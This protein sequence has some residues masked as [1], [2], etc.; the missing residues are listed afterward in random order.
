[1]RGQEEIPEFMMK[2]I[3]LVIVLVFV[4]GGFF[5]L[6][7]FKATIEEESG[8]RIMTD[9]AQNVLASGCSAVPGH[10]GLLDED[11]IILQSG[12]SGSCNEW[13]VTE[14]ANAGYNDIYND[15]LK[16]CYAGGYAAE[17]IYKL[18]GLTSDGLP[19]LEDFI[20]EGLGENFEIVDIEKRIKEIETN[21]EICIELGLEDE[22]CI[23]L[24][25]YSKDFVFEIQD[26]NNCKD[27]CLNEYDGFYCLS[28]GRPV[29]VKITAENSESEKIEHETGPLEMSVHTGSIVFPAS[30][31]LSD[32]KVVPARMLILYPYEEKCSDMHCGSYCVFCREKEECENAGCLWGEGCKRR[33]PA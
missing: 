30:L 21:D 9:F 18:S 23:A 11:M 27:L 3:A 24:K 13:L 4:V 28:F 10:K 31:R 26:E 20:A 6:T 7:E 14:T 2:A 25:D 29:G 32:G 22:E 5:S 1:M 17:K 19:I 12:W 15:M 8:K 33:A 16:Y